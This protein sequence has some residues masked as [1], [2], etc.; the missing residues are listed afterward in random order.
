MNLLN[1]K[2]PHRGPIFVLAHVSIFK[3]LYLAEMS[4]NLKIPPI[5]HLTNWHLM[6]C[7]PK[8]LWFIDML[9]GSYLEKY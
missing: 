1:R 2:N 5:K 8:L 9:N 3:M 6:I 4:L 7:K